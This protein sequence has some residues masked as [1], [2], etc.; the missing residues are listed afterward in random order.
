M[1]TVVPT[2]SHW[3]LGMEWNRSGYWPW[4]TPYWIL[5][6]PEREDKWT[7]LLAQLAPICCLI[8]NRC[9]QRWLDPLGTS[10]LS[11]IIPGWGRALSLQQHCWHL[12][13]GVLWAP[14]ASA[15]SSPL[16]STNTVVAR[17]LEHCLLQLG[18]WLVLPL[19]PINTTDR[20]GEGNQSM[21]LMRHEGR[22]MQN[23]WSG[24]PYWGYR[25]GGRVVF[26]L[27]FG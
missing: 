25:S 15:S 27:M 5:L 26:P 1:Y 2:G 20:R 3:L 12:P 19:G 18:E 6:T 24:W 7:A 16:G 22:R 23:Q 11:L 21:L 10:S 17:E 13:G 9:R 4:F 8:D 14:P